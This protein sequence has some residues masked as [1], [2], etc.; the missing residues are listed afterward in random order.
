MKDRWS[1]TRRTD[2]TFCGHIE[3]PKER[4]PHVKSEATHGM[5]P[6]VAKNACD[7]YPM[8]EIALEGT[9]LK[10]KERQIRQRNSTTP[11]SRVFVLGIRCAARWNAGRYPFPVK[12]ETTHG[13][14]T[15]ILKTP[16]TASRRRK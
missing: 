9:L 14:P 13:M 7:G 6:V 16:L 3:Q 2:E 1:N 11:R 12:S 5:Q 15:H 8:E 4:F 10:R